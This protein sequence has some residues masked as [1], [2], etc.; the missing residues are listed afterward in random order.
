MNNQKLED[1]MK[2][3]KSFEISKHQDD[4]NK[5]RGNGLIYQS[6]SR[7]VRVGRHREKRLVGINSGE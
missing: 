5:V 1:S 7:I 3:G 2:E 6:R 4:M